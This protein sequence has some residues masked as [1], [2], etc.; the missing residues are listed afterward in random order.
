MLEGIK[1]EK[2][3]ITINMLQFVDEVIFL[4]KAKLPSIKEYT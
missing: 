1:M 3:E 4:C 2:K